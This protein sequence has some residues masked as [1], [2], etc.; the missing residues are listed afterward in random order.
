[1]TGVGRDDEQ[2]FERVGQRA[3]RDDGERER[4]RAAADESD[5]DRRAAQDSPARL[6]GPHAVEPEHDEQE[7]DGESDEADER[8][9]GVT[10]CDVQMPHWSVQIRSR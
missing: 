9:S 8:H 2:I 7:A 1:M 10:Q 5:A 6:G 3:E 4:G